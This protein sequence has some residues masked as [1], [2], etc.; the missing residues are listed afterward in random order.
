MLTFTEKRQVFLKMIKAKI[1]LDSAT[2]QQKADSILDNNAD[3]ELMVLLEKK[4]NELFG[5]LNDN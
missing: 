1:M 5:S 2:E 3:D 4:F